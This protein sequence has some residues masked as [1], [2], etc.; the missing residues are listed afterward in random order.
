MKP[1]GS[2][3]NLLYFGLILPFLVKASERDIEAGDAPRLPSQELRIA[4]PNSLRTMG[5]PMPVPS[6]SELRHVESV[7]DLTRLD[8]NGDGRIDEEDERM[9]EFA[10]QAYF[11]QRNS[12]RHRVLPYLRRRVRQASDSP[13]QY[14]REGV[15]ALR[16][17]MR[18][19]RLEQEH[20]VAG[21]QELVLKAVTE[22]LH[23]TEEEAMNYQQEAHRRVPRR[24]CVCTAA[25]SSSITA[26][27][28][29]AVAL[30]IKFTESCT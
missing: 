14:E 3:N 30:I 22:A 13:L 11:Y 17:I 25:V 6:R 1:G 12:T 2:M 16:Q 28:G 10:L 29:A 5:E 21:I 23:S 18:G 19:E 4:V 20:P 24:R 8:L 9:A 27:M 26:V 15:E 7:Q